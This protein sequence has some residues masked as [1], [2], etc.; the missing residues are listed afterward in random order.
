MKYERK[1]IAY[2]HLTIRS[3]RIKKQGGLG[4]LLRGYPQAYPQKLFITQD[5][6]AFGLQVI[7]GLGVYEGVECVP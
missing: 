6:M 7:N 3:I 1:F 5:V 2:G 4:G